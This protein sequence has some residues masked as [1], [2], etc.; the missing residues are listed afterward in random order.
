M[1]NYLGY[2][3]MVNSVYKVSIIC[4]H[5]LIVIVFLS[6][7]ASST[8]VSVV[9]DSTCNDVPSPGPFEVCSSSA[10]LTCCVEGCDEWVGHWYIHT[11]SGKNK[12]IGIGAHL[13]ATLTSSWQTFLCAITSLNLDCYDDGSVTLKSI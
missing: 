8:S 6:I 4:G 11:D 2:P 13:N 9:V 12:F 7:A 5:I 1:T 3:L 10:V